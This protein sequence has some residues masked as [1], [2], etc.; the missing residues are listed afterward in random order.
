[1]H[2]IALLYMKYYFWPIKI[3]EI[4]SSISES[5]ADS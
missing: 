4:S 3:Q 1:L 2:T 5:A